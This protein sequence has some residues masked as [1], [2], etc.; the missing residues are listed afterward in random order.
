MNNPAEPDSRSSDDDGRRDEPTVHR[1]HQPIRACLAAYLD[2]I[3]GHG[4]E[5]GSGTGQHIIGFARAF[6]GMTWWPSDIEPVNLGSI[7]AWRRGSGLD[8]ISAPVAIDAAQTDWRLGAPGRPP[9]RDLTALI[10]INVLHISP[11]AVS[12]GLIA[13]AGRHLAPDAHLF[14][15]GPF[16]R[17]GAH[18]AESNARFDAWLRRQNPDWGVRDMV[19]LETEASGHGLGLARVADMPR[20]NFV[21]VF[22]PEHGP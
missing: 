17:N 3:S 11:W 22:S 20:D 10:A 21:L 7:D 14:V 13:A 12:Q 6:P 16:A 18:T 1:N 4:L 2:G 15:Y 8:N 9:A 5:I 19:D